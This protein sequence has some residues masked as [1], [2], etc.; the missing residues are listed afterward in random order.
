MY[1]VLKAKLKKMLTNQKYLL[2]NTNVLKKPQNHIER[3]GLS[4]L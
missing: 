4:E 1:R 2:W 3:E